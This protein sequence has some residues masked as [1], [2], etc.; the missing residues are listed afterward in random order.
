[1]LPP[2]ELDSL[3]QDTVPQV[4]E[5]QPSSKHEGSTAPSCLVVGGTPADASPAHSPDST[6]ISSTRSADLDSMAHQASRTDGSSAALRPGEGTAKED[7][8]ASS[9]E[10]EVREAAMVGPCCSV[11]LSCRWFCRF[12]RCFLLVV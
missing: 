5:K 10:D 2:Q 4:M 11:L 8:S 1:M 3:L 6:T 7:G 12:G 9:T